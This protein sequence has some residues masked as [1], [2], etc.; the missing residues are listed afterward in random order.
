M[1][2]TAA[3]LANVEVVAPKELRVKVREVAE[4]VVGETIAQGVGKGA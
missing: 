2:L 3:R 4:R 1:P